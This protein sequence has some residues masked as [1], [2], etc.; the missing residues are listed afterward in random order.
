V[1]THREEYQRLSTPT[2]K[3]PEILT[4]GTKVLAQHWHVYICEM[5][6][7][8]WVLMVAGLVVSLLYASSSPVSPL[9]SLEVLKR[10][11]VG[12]VMASALISLVYSPV[13]KKS[14]AHINPA[15][16]LAFFRL[17]KIKPWDAAFYILAQCGGGVLG[18]L[19]FAG[20]VGSWASDP[21]VNYIVTTPGI[22]G[23]AA[24]FLAEIA[25]TFTM[26]FMVLHSI[27]S[28]RFA[29]YT[30]I[31]AGVLLAILILTVAPISGT[32]LN[33]ARSF[34][35]AAVAI[36]WRDLWVYFIAPPIGAL[37][38][39]LVYQ[40]QSKAQPVICAKLYHGDSKLCIFLNCGYEHMAAKKSSTVGR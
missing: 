26:M 28:K 23:P 34:G 19:L 15:I 3:L 24:A 1:D 13:G 40:W 37:L 10:L 8:S 38:A 20:I 14:G 4:A 35:S 27:N 29:P 11:L 7:L 39:T 33:P 36:F 9:V 21:K 31:L 32:S 6:G 22:G 30:G 5:L 18:I 12:A 16:T 2:N 17:G 25:I